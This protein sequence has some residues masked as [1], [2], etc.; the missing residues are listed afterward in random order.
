[1]KKFL[2]LLIIISLFLANGAGAEGPSYEKGFQ[3]KLKLYFE[4]AQNKIIP[5]LQKPLNVINNQVKKELSDIKDNLYQ[6]LEE[7]KIS[8]LDLIKA[9]WK[10]GIKLQ[11][12]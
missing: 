8:L 2:T 7:M 12:Q 6:E 9:G 4:K 11:I 10:K 5:A 1:M 3:E